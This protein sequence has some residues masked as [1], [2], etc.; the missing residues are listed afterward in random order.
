MALYLPESTGQ[1]LSISGFAG[2]AVNL[3][4]DQSGRL[5][6]DFNVGGTAD[7][8]KVQ[9]DTDPVRK[10]AEELAKQKFD[11]EKK[12]LEQTLKEKAEDVLKKLFKKDKK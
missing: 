3:F 10:R 1:K 6:L 9:L 8:P 7:N 12:K 4:K 5:K 11:E 2:E